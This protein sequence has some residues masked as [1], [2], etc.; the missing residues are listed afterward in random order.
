MRLAFIGGGH[1]ATSLIGALCARGLEPASIIVAEPVTP[2]REALAR[3]YGVG[4]TED[5]AAAARAADVLV[6]AVKP[7]DVRKVAA[8]IAAAI[9]DRRRLVVSVAAGIRLAD[10]GRWLGAGAALV[11]AMPNQPALI[12]RGITALCAGPGVSAAER[13]RA[14]SILAASGETLWIE[15]ESLLDVVTAV[16][17]SGPAYFFL[18]MEALAEAGR[19]QGLPADVARRLAVVTA[20]GAGEMAAA[21]DV[22][23][24]VL[25]EQVTSQGG[26]TA[27]AL[28]VLD[29]ADLRGIFLAA[30][31]AATRR[32]AE[33]AAQSGAQ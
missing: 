16:S 2:R 30:V 19:A 8:D 33:L 12:G 14:E 21:A 20:A 32:A 23:P 31:A 11:R 4:T 29:A 26:T 18:L 13:A 28:A 10:L 22:P 24:A 7:Q 17:G 6:I 3:D 5:N 15:P 1:M 9:A 27:A 25:R